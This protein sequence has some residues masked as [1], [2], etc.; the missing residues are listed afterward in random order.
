MGAFGPGNI[1]TNLV[2]ICSVLPGLPSN[3]VISACGTAEVNFGNAI[4]GIF[5][6]KESV[7]GKV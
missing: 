3:G 1:I 6:G 2:I 5:A 7:E 4:A